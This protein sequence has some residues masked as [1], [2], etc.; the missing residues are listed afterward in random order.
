M[1]RFVVYV[2]LAVTATLP[3]LMMRVTGTHLTP[4]LD[5]LIF[6]SAILGAGFMLSWGAEAAE[7]HVAQG[8]AMAVL[9]L[10]TVLPEYAVDIYYTLQAGRH[11][12]S[13][14]AQFAAANMTGANRQADRQTA[15]Q[16]K[17]WIDL[18]ERR[19][20]GTLEKVRVNLREGLPFLRQ[21]RFFKNRFNG[22]FRLAGPAVNAFSRINI[23]LGRT[24]V[25]SFMDAVHRTHIH[26]GFIFHVNTR[27]SDNISHGG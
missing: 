9:A 12:G 4:L 10:V 16:G 23:K 5:T 7:G 8:L 19:L 14:Y 25:L 22:T 27:F 3:G 21:R 26:T 13:E 15:G 17:Q 20:R 2:V 24:P 1:R 6:G 18:Q 11:P